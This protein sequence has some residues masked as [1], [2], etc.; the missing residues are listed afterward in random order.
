[1]ETFSFRPKSLE[2]IASVIAKSSEKIKVTRYQDGQVDIET[3]NLT[4]GQRT[5]LRDIFSALGLVEGL[6]GA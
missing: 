4:A 5:A 6:S 1:M 2:E 3:P